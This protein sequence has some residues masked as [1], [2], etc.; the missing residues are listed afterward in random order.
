MKFTP[1]LG[2]DLSGSLAGI[3]A[4]HNRGGPYFRNRAIPVDPA[5]PFQTVIRAFVAS[6]TSGWLND[7]SAGQRQ[8]WDAYALAVPLPDPLGNPRNVGGLAMYV[9]SNVPRLQ[10]G[11]PRVDN[12]PGIF[13]LG[14]F[15]APVMAGPSEAGQTVSFAFDNTDDWANEDDAGMLF[16]LSRAQ[17]ASVNFFKGPY[18]FAAI[19][20]GDSAVPPVSPVVIPAPFAFIVGQRLFTEVKVTRADGRLSAKFR[21]NQL[22][23]A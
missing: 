9:R 8:S 17:N 5:T 21:D 10:A 23:V 11:E 20:Q 14:D 12:A 6:L 22:A 13:N 4:S 7:L 3:T 19:V 2:T 15:T 18:R 1:L 16:Q